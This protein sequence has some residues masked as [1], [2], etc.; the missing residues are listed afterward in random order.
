MGLVGESTH[1]SA[2][3]PRG[4]SLRAPLP[5]R[6]HPGQAFF[7]LSTEGAAILFFHGLW[8]V[9]PSSFPS[10]M[11]WNQGRG[12]QGPSGMWGRERGYQTGAQ[13]GPKKKN[14]TDE[15][16]NC[17]GCLGAHPPG[18]RKGSWGQPR[19]NVQVKAVS[20]N[21]GGELIPPSW[22]ISSM[23]FPHSAPPLLE[24]LRDQVQTTWGC[25]YAW[26]TAL[27]KR[28]TVAETILV[29]PLPHRGLRRAPHTLSGARGF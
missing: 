24:A 14:E 19:R 15:K 23:S 1:P 27:R 2:P 7:S 18:V 26:P 8:E 22:I 25:A 12:T 9:N 6:S 5:P 21:D 11:M 10:L 13:T 29:W 3:D 4:A 28:H 16:C 17:Q 20:G